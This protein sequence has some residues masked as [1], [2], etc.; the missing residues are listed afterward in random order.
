MDSFYSFY[1][2]FPEIF[3]SPSGKSGSGRISEVG[4]QYFS[5]KKR[6]MG[7]AGM[8]YSELIKNFEIRLPQS[9]P[10]ALDGGVR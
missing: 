4:F 10:L 1:K 3:H 7:R 8:A 9:I 6:L 2:C 5:K